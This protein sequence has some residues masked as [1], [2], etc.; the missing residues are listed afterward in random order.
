MTDIRIRRLKKLKE[1][2][3]RTVFVDLKGW[4]NKYISRNLSSRVMKNYNVTKMYDW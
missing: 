4:E 2:I 3:K 1:I